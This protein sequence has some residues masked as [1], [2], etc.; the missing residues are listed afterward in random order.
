MRF[1]YSEYRKFRFAVHIVGALIMILGAPI[2]WPILIYL[3]RPHLSPEVE[4]EYMEKQMAARMATN[5][6]TPAPPGPTEH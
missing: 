3:D 1:S 2:Y 4:K 6:A 5:S